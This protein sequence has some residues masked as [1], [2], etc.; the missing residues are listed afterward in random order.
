MTTATALFADGSAN[1]KIIAG[2]KTLYIDR[3][4]LFIPYCLP[5]AVAPVTL[6]EGITTIGPWKVTV[7]SGNFPTAQ[8]WSSAWNGECSVNLPRGTYTLASIPSQTSYRNKS[9]IDTFWNDKKIPAFLRPHIPGIWKD[10]D[11]IHEFLTDQEH[12]HAAPDS[13]HIKLEFLLAY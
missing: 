10:S 5:E 12:I 2:G 3:K 11:L 8:G 1:K 7:K 4:R 13:T 9:R 6:S